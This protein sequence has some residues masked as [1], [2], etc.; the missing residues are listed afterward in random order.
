MEVTSYLRSDVGETGSQGQ[1]SAKT[2]ETAGW[3]PKR[4]TGETN[5]SDARRSC[6]KKMDDSYK[7]TENADVIP[8]ET[9]NSVD[10]PQETE[11]LIAS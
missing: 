7:E 4:L 2:R 8:K 10:R 1:C 3:I 9:E 5:M 11:M 6:W